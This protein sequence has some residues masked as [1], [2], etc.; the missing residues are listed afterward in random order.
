MASSSSNKEQTPGETPKEDEGT[1]TTYGIIIDD[2]AKASKT[3]LTTFIDFA[4]KNL[5]EEG[6]SD[7]DLWQS[8]R[9]EFHG[10]DANTFGRA[11]PTTVRKFREM[12]YDRGVYS[13]KDNTRVADHLGKLL[14]DYTEWPAAVKRSEKKQSTTPTAPTISTSSTGKAP[15]YLPILPTSPEVNT[16]PVFPE[17]GNTLNTRLTSQYNQRIKKESSPFLPIGN[18]T[19]S[20]PAHTLKNTCP[21]EISNLEKAYSDDLKYSGKLDAF[22]WK[23]HIFMDKCF[24]A[25]VPEASYPIAFS[26]MLID[27]AL[28][29]YYANHSMWPGVGIGQVCETFRTNFEG[30]EHQTSLM[31]EWNKVNLKHT[32]NL[33]KQKTVGDCVDII[34]S[35]L[36]ELSHALNP[37][38]RQPG[39]IYSKLLIACEDVPACVIA[40]SK[41]ADTLNGLISDLRAGAARYDRM[42]PPKPA[43]DEAM[44]TDRKYVNRF[45]NQRNSG[46]F[47]D[48][49]QGKSGQYRYT[50]NRDKSKDKR[51]FVCGKPGCWSTNHPQKDR[52]KSMQQLIMDT[53]G[54]EGSP[55]PTDSD[56][57]PDPTPEETDSEA[58]YTSLGP[59]NGNTV[60]KELANNSTM[61]A[62]T[63]EHPTPPA[64]SNETYTVVTTESDDVPIF[65]SAPASIY[66]DERFYGIMVDP[67][68]AHISSAGYGQYLALKKEQDIE[69]DTS[70]AGESRFRFGI[71]TAISKG[72]VTIETPIGSLTFHVVDAG[73]PFLL[74]LGDLDRKGYY[75]DNIKNRLVG[76]KIDGIRQEVKIIRMFGHGWMVWKQALSQC[77]TS[78]YIEDSNTYGCNMTDGEL[79]RLHRRFGHP[80]AARLATIL[81]RSDHDYNREAINQLTRLCT[82]CQK[83]GRSPRRFRFTLHDEDMRFN[84]NVYIDIM[85]M[86]S[87]ALPVLHVVDEATRFQAARFLKDISTSTVWNTLRNC[88]M[89]TYLGPPDFI[90]H[91]SGTQFTSSDFV[92]KAKGMSITTKCVPVEAHHSIGRVER[93]HAPLRRAFSIIKEELPQL[94]NAIALQMATKAINDTAGPDGLTPTLLVFGTYPRM[95]DDDSPHASI[96]ERRETMNKAMEEVSKL[97]T[98]RQV[99][100][101]LAERNGPDV[102]DLVDAPIGSKVLV[103]R[104]KPKAWKGP[105]TLLAIDGGTVNIDLPSGPTVFA[106]TSVK[107]YHE[108]EETLSSPSP[109]TTTPPAGTGTDGNDA[110]HPDDE[111]STSEEEPRRPQ[112]A[113]RLPSRYQHPVDVAS[114]SNDQFT[115]EVQYEHLITKKEES[116]HELAKKLRSEGLMRYKEGPFV[117]ARRNEIQGLIAEGVFKVVAA[118]DVPADVRIFGCRF[119]D[120]VKEKNS[121]PYEKSR[122]VVQAHN[123]GNKKGVLTQSPTIQRASQR[124]ILCFHAI[125][126]RILCTRDISQA[127]I[128]STS[129]LIREFFVRPP[130][131]TDLGNNLLKVLRPLYGVPEAGTHWFKTY[132][133][134][135]TDRLLLKPSTYDPC[136]LYNDDAIVGLQTDDTLFCGTEK[137]IQ[138]E[139]EQLKIA[140]FPAKSID[141]L[142]EKHGITFNGTLITKI[143][144]T[145][146]LHRLVLIVRLHDPVRDHRREETD[147]RHHGS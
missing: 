142:G 118:A 30:A 121:V 80:S 20:A 67:G 108:D 24:K 46:R 1:M 60:W 49:K 33:N 69:L 116:S 71:G 92:Q 31:V 93:Y 88:W 113:R 136:L 59:V 94:T 66:N 15:D 50:K 39:F 28:E 110:D 124:I 62:I 40:C 42:N 86:D 57:D 75:F 133:T 128:N 10:W 8:F 21:R 54:K 115:F 38:L 4:H 130:E 9:E 146:P 83:N 91:D 63:H 17:D 51:C 132:H 90:T 109:A 73:T 126:N 58:F 47:S 144:A 65:T 117:E 139:N 143:G 44:F 111:S 11:V 141:V 100:E 87:P 131:G 25:G 43:I 105:Y 77:Y 95:S 81:D 99:S 89:D 145:Y 72:T 114:G 134:H 104:E 106:I 41:P 107:L 138:M 6:Q 2:P 52:D 18:N 26:T 55:P 137:Y 45:Q 127:Y 135:H 120:D 23:Y 84:Y 78:A 70:R 129:L 68:A 147:D 61:H 122:L 85:Y 12:L 5:S 19:K 34:I 97:Y 103:W 102:S 82:M 53:E 76:K 27:D 79:K 140:K 22:D 14:K 7:K 119:V 13:P 37:T 56:D 29:F 35:R 98:K 48:S 96:A 36:R 74:C 112:R 125:L 32:I 64:S 3:A 123:D 16:N 101:A